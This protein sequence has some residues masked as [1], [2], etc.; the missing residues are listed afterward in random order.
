[1]R[2]TSKNIALEKPP[3]QDGV[4][5][6][7]VA[8]PAGA[9]P[10]VLEFLI[11]RFAHIPREE[12]RARML[13]GAVLD[14]GLTPLPPDAPYRPGAR[15]FY[16]RSISA[17]PSIPFAETVL[18][19]DE[20]LVVAD[21]PH[22][23]PVIPTG[24]YL[25]ETL[26]AR[27]RRRLSIDTLTPVHRLDRETAGIV[28]FAIRP[29]ERARYFELFRR[30]AVRKLYH[31]VAPVRADLQLPLTVRNRLAPS[32]HFMQ[33]HTVEGPVNAETDIDLIERRAELALYELRPLTGKRHQLRAHLSA[34]GTPIENDRIYPQL[35]PE[36]RDDAARKQEY[37][38]PLQL[39]A[40][41]IEFVDPITAE[42]RH[43]ETR[44]SLSW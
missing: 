15:V 35:M 14:E 8:L 18:F 28:V 34:L 22:F 42:T 32:A 21:K 13:R 2:S 30:R 3:P 19:Q 20:H 26:V 6:S 23:L 44:R 16:Y 39:L 9:W 12:W 5:A 25:R 17:E 27:L 7:I 31:A 37:R 41:S 38:Q 29:A 24:R 4:G 36:A 10:T 1:M 40:K 11:E 33:M 43:F